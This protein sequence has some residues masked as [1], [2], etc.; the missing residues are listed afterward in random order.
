MGTSFGFGFGFGFGFALAFGVGFAVLV[1]ARI[2]N[3]C[4]RAGLGFWLWLPDW[5]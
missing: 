2:G 1:L 3:L 5:C 4:W